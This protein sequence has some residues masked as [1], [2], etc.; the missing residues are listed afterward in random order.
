MEN[1]P[2]INGYLRH[3]L[4][5]GGSDLHLSVDYPPK[6]RIHGNLQVLKACSHQLALK[7][8]DSND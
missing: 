2:V 6:A 4:E 5:L 3:M 1:E 7:G 8:K